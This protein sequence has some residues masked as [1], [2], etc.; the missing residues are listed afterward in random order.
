M[1]ALQECWESVEKEAKGLRIGE[2]SLSEILGCIHGIIFD[3][4]FKS[5][6]RYYFEQCEELHAKIRALEQR[7]LLSGDERAHNLKNL[8]GSTR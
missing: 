3:N 1:E 4:E 6:A 2:T 5:L 7:K 8:S